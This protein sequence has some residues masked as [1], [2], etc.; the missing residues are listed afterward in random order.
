[1]ET[2]QTEVVD[3]S[4]M[5]S[6]ELTALAAQRELEEQQARQ[7]SREDYQA[8]ENN[9]VES[10][11]AKALALNAK[12]KEEKKEWEDRL[13]EFTEYLRTYSH[14]EGDWKGNM[15]LV[16]KDQTMKVEY[17]LAQIGDYDGRANEGAQLILDFIATELA[18]KPQALK[19]VK[20]LL[21]PKSGKFDRDNILKLIAMEDDYLNEGWRRGLQ[22]LKESYKQTGVKSYIRV[23][24][25]PTASGKWEPVPLN[26]SAV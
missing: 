26:L 5:S 7:R 17:C 9:L 23:Y 25:R 20:S 3:F 24:Q 11:A 10:I 21:E 4:K 8:K 6:K 19:M 12:M 22:L 15:G 1:M 13:V 16:N 2:K 14:R 18:E